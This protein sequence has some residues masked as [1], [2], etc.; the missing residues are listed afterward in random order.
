MEDIAIRSAH[1]RRKKR[2][3]LLRTVGKLYAT[4]RFTMRQ[5]A[6]MYR[7]AAFTVCRWIQI[8]D[9]DRCSICETFYRFL[10]FCKYPDPVEAGRMLPGWPLQTRD[11]RN[12]QPDL[13]YKPPEWMLSKFKGRYPEPTGMRVRVE[14]PKPMWFSSP[15]G[16]DDFVPNPIHWIVE[17]VRRQVDQA[18]NPGVRG[19]RVGH[20]PACAADQRSLVVTADFPL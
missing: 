11:G 2:A 7:I 5:L 15:G 10:C 4:G 9:S 14:S 17:D 1:A 3:P 20:Q 13:W 19:R 18:I 6:S 8:F 16:E 12:P